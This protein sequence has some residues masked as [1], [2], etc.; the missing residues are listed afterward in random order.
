MRK[1]DGTALEIRA[2]DFNGE[3]LHRIYLLE[4]EF[5]FITIYN[6]DQIIYATYKDI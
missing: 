3:I 1:S 4:L 5:V 2:V 6:V